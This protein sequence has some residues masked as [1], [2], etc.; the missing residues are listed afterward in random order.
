MLG[1]E[2]L[3]TDCEAVGKRP[4][5]RYRIEL[6][7]PYNVYAVALVYMRWNEVGACA[8]LWCYFHRSA[9]CQCVYAVQDLRKQAGIDPDKE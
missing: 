5:T 1:F 2:G 3:V 4:G 7:F 6:L 8:H 9:G